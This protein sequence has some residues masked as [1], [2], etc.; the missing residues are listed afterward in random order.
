M[1]PLRMG[2]TDPGAAIYLKKG[3]SAM[4]NDSKERIEQMISGA[5]QAC[6]R[7]F[8]DLERIEEANTRR[9][10]DAF[11]DNSVALRHFSPTNGYGYDDIGRDNLERIFSDLFRTEAAIVRQIGRAHV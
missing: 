2:K 11:R 9:I 6:A 7:S 1:L 8:A 10:L 4:T 5:E 3:L